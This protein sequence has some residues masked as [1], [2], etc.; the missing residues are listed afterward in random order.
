MNPPVAILAV[1][2]FAA[3]ALRLMRA[4]LRLLAGEADALVARETAAMRAERG[5]LTGLA[6]AE[7]GVRRARRARV[8]QLARVALWLAWLAV[9]PATPWAAQLYAAG[10]VLWLPIGRAGRRTAR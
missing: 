1:L 9:P 8:A 3:V 10:A 2:G 4:V 5:D 7:A 6:E